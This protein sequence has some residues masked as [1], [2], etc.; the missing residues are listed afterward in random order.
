M[1][2][3]QLLTLAIVLLTAALVAITAY[4]AYQTR[5]M[6][7]EMKAARSVQILPRL[8]PT[9]EYIAP[10]AGLIRFQNVGP[11]PA[12]NVNV[13]MYLE[14]GHGQERRLTQAVIAPGEGHSFMPR[15]EETA[16][17]SLESLMADYNLLCLAGTFDDAMGAHHQVDECFDI[18][19]SKELLY[20]AR[21]IIPDNWPRTSAKELEKIRR[22]LEKIAE[23]SR[24]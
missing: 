1:N 23:R 15:I 14:P 24:G 12:L 5:Q 13:T 21:R 10:D 9:I 7:V 3:D 22:T 4:Y 17:L 8:V 19:E 2:G 6:V 11:G 18:R 16:T 20:S